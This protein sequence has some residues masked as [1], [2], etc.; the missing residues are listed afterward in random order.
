MSATLEADAVI[1]GAGVAGALVAWR[2][3][4]QGLRVLVVEAGG[5]VDR[6][7]AVARYQ[8]SPDRGT[9]DPYPELEHA[10]RP[11]PGEPDPYLLFAGPEAYPVL[12]ERLVG[13]STWHWHGMS[14]RLLPYD[15][16]LRSRYGVGVDWPIDYAALEPWYC[17][18]ERALGVSGDDAVGPPRSA[19]YP[20]P[21][22]PMTY[23]DRRVQQAVAALGLTVAADPAARNAVPYDGRQACCGS[24]TCVPICPTGAKY[25]ASVHV[26]KA[27][28]LGAR[29]ID[30]TL[31]TSI[32]IDASGRVQSLSARRSDGSAL[33]LRGR[34]TVLAAN[35]VET[36]R[37]ML[38]SATDALPA[39]VGN[40]SGQVG[41]NLMDHLM[42]DHASLTLDP[43]FPYRGP[44]S[45]A[46]MDELRDGPFRA[47]HAAFRMEVNNVGWTG[48]GGHPLMMA[49]V[50]IRQG[51]RGEALDRALADHVSRQLRLRAIVEQLPDPENRVE[52]DRAQLDRTGLPRP[53]VRWRLGEYTAR[54]M[55]EA[56]RWL[57][58]VADAVGV[59]EKH[60]NPGWMIGNHPMGTCRMGRSPADSVVDA[61]LRSHD[62]P[63]LF[64]VGSAVFP[65]GGSATPT[66]TIAAL[67]LRAA[68]TIGA[69]LRA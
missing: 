18:A 56:G 55:A 4:E 42:V 11:R 20:M 47:Q 10:P 32:N 28:Q 59:S 65:T 50:F 22:I 26:G 19:P 5:R 30:N 44:Q 52:V 8:A 2:L 61:D 60:I 33:S 51:L 58:R 25:D 15:F 43:V 45:T 12:Y 66:L 14:P 49:R 38:L 36:P 40:Q 31:V 41:R 53:T 7:D 67:A 1:V 69:D 23:V 16:Q 46:G 39:G 64:V 24:G 9:L 68:D 48:F 54:G 27:Q 35:G 34:R 13:G 63:D 17:A 6:A 57:D 29:F 62:H 3:A 21:P 37:L